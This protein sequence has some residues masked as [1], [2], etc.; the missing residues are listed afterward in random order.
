MP[1]ERRE[2]DTQNLSP[3]DPAFPQVTEINHR[4]KATII[5]SLLLQNGA[6]MLPKRLGET[7]LEDIN[8]LTSIVPK[9]GEEAINK[10]ISSLQKMLSN[11]EINLR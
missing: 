9:D 10:L 11:G 3:V 5:V 7:L 1:E 4:Q 8:N 6:D 2:Q